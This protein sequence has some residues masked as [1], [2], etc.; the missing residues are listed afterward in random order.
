MKSIQGKCGFVFYMIFLKFVFYDRLKKQQRDTV[1]M[2]D[3]VVQKER[4][5][6]LA[7]EKDVHSMVKLE[8]LTHNLTT[9][10]TE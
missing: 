1:R 5:R 9:E 3:N 7:I 4:N 10:E 2:K 6:N 8:Q